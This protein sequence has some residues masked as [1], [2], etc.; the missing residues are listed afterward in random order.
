LTLSNVPLTDAVSLL[1]S[2]VRVVIDRP[3]GSRHPRHPDIVYP[4]NYGYV[5]GTR[6]GD[7]MEM[8]AYVLDIAEPVEEAIGTVIAIVQ[9]SDDAEDKLVVAVDHL[10][11]R[12]EEISEIVHFQECFFKS[13]IVLFQDARKE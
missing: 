7:G 8:D 11:R 4:V 6:A 12:A 1:G 10:A 5:P 3:L 13:R 9:R 2:I